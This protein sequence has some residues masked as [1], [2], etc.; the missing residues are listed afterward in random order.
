MSFDTTI[1]QANADLDAVPIRDNFNALK[2]LIDVI[3]AQ[4]MLLAGRA[5]LSGGDN[6]DVAWSLVSIA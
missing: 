1:P 2:T 5:T 4:K 3:P 6:S